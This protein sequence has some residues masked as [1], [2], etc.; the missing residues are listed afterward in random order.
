MT[1]VLLADIGATNCRFALIGA[2][3]RPERVIKLRDSE[4]PSLEAGVARYLEETGAHPSAGVLAIAG[5]IEGDAVKMTNRP[6]AFRFSE[7]AKRFGWSGVRGINDFEAVAWSLPHLRDDDVR[8]LGA[9]TTK[10]NGAKA[11]FGPGTGLGV[12]ALLP[13]GERWRVVPTEGGHVSFGP[14]IDAEEA[15]FARLRA[16]HGR[17]SAETVLCGPG[18]EHLFVAMHGEVQTRT[19]AQII[20][21]A[22]AGEAAAVACVQLFV[23]LFGRFAG[24]LALMFKALGGVYVGGGVSRRIAKFLDAPAFRETF[25]N[26][27]PYADLLRR[28]PTTLITLDEPGLLG[29]AAVAR[30]EGFV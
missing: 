22:N 24:D 30:T 3:G 18:L 14:A 4:V 12:A 27:P 20:A 23:R 15:V 9:L 6:W 13:D 28:I 2:G 10:P 7:L 19:S 11:A 26:H 5:P 8:P 29:C 17:V 1:G 16:R 21:D 25:E